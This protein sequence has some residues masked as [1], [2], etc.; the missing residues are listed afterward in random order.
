MTPPAA[1]VA[2][3]PRRGKHHRANPPNDDEQ[4][5]EINV[6]FGGSMSII[7]KT[8]GK[9]LE[10]EISLTQR[11]EPRR[12]MRWSYVDIS[13]RPDDHQITVSLYRRDVAQRVPLAV[14]VLTP[15][16]ALPCGPGV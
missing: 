13:F 7:S 8:Q 1:Q 16:I 2:Q 9:K 5:G 11:I 6:I 15:H 12:L 10:Q 3:E 4:M 14:V